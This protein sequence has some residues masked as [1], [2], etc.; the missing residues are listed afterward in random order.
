MSKL[1]HLSKPTLIKLLIEDFVN[2][3]PDA[4]RATIRDLEIRL[5]LMALDDLTLLASGLPEN[6]LNQLPK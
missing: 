6:T 3:F 2:S 5:F 1:G 4:D